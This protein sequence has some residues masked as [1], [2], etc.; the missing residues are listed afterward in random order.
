M[1]RKKAAGRRIKKLQKKT[2]PEE[3]LA[4]DVAGAEEKPATNVAGASETS[5][6]AD[7][8]N[9]FFRIGGAAPGKATT[10]LIVNSDNVV[11]DDIWAWRADHGN[12]VGWTANTADTGVIVNGNDVTAYGLFAEHFQKYE[13]IWNGERGRTIMFQNEMPY[14]VPDQASWTHDGVNGYAAYKVGGSVQAHEAWGIG[15]YCFFNAGPDIHASHAFEVPDT[16][17]VKLHDVLTVFLTG[18][19]GIDHVVNNTGAAVNSSN[20]VTNVVSYP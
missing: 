19:G 8:V 17:G 10:A 4:T 7:K 12:G 9:V 5:A 18:N 2:Q 13:V 3:K 6:S 14:D 15:S 20:Q 1:P 16:P 11:L